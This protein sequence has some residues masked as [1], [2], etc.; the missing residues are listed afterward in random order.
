M[1][2]YSIPSAEETRV[3]FHCG[4]ELAACG[5]IAI[6]TSFQGKGQRPFGLC[7]Y[8]LLRNLKNEFEFNR[9]PE[10]QTGNAD[11]HAN[12]NLLW[13]K[14]ISKQVRDGVRHYRLVEKVPMS[15]HEDCESDSACDLIERAQM[16]FNRGQTAQS[17]RASRIA[18]SFDIE[19]LSKAAEILRLVIDN[20]K[21]AG[22][23]K[24]VASLRCLDVVA[25]RFRRGR[26][27]NAKLLQRLFC[28]ARLGTH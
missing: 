26:E 13:T 18:S 16:L 27:L 21:H 23:E 2:G 5:C 9:A 24:Q 10:W 25:K 12:R 15:C 20:R 8:L 4:D 28:A 11:D 6:V 22:Q 1:I 7:L 17:R 14:Y 3:V 19:L